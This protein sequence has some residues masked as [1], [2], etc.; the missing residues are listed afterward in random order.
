MLE[1][2]STRGPHDPPVIFNESM[3]SAS[4][5]PSQRIQV[6]VRIRHTHT[7]PLEPLSDTTPFSKLKSLL[8]SSSSMNY[9]GLSP[10]AC[11]ELTHSHP[12]S[13]LVI[14]DPEG[15]KR[16][17]D[18]SYDFLLTPRDQQIQ[19]YD[20]CVRPLI[21]KCLEGF[22]GCVFCYG[23]TGSGKTYTMEGPKT[24]SPDDDGI[25]LRAAKHI[26]QHIQER[27]AM[28]A[29]KG[30]LEYMMKASY[31]EIYQEQLTDLLVDKNEQGR[32]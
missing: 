12:L 28:P 14:R 11:I 2:S 23:Q 9:Y 4:S 18:F 27:V 8:S 22:N 32:N 15:R 31:M 19:V 1:S 29:E 5:D 24:G 17:K 25:I 30:K 10:D 6:A 21:Q 13:S 7:Q 16:K 20:Q 26:T 3:L